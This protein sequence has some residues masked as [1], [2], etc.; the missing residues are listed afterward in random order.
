M[1]KL[2]FVIPCYCSEKTLPGVVREINKIMMSRQNAFDYEII[3]VNDASPKDRTKEVIEE[4]CEKDKRIKG[5][6]FSRNFGQHSAVMAGF[7]VAEGDYIVNLDDDGQIPLD[8]LFLLIE[9]LEEGYDLVFAKYIETEKRSWIR[10]MGT[11]GREWLNG[12]L[13]EK[14]KDLV[15]NSFFVARRFVIE[16]VLQYK[17]PYPY[18]GG[19]LYRATHNVVNVEVHHRA[20]AQGSS[21]YTIRKLARLMLN[22]MTSFSVKPLRIATVAGM[23]TGGI[24]FL[25]MIFIIIRKLTISSISDGYSSLMATILF[26]GGV[27]LI[28]VGLLGEYIGRIYISLNNAPQYV[29]K[30]RFNLEARKKG[31]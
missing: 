16:E 24:G 29:V 23:L 3:L 1:K 17:N 25:W 4:L 22:E 12:V 8:E 10:K 18:L 28:T 26:L 14:P 31:L 6:S 15:F 27:Q 30:E 7:S 2:S 13:L 9:K 5:M 11:S 19:L 20:R 21:G